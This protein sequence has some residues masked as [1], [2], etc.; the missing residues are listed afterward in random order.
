[1]L[2]TMLVVLEL[3]MSTDGIDGEYLREKS[4]RY[5]QLFAPQ[6]HSATY[7]ALGIGNGSAK[8]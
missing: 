8:H 1:M 4:L 6:G 2:A 7:L 3:L 5:S